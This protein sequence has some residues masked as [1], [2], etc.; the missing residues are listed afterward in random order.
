MFT[1]HSSLTRIIAQAVASARQDG[2]DYVV[3]TER[4]IR[5]VQMVEPDLAPGTVRRMVETLRQD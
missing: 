3:Q 4:A 5:A 2:L 1:L